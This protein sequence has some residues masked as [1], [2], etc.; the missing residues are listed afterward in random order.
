MSSHPD[1]IRSSGEA[2]AS[3]RG[4]VAGSRATG[5]NKTKTVVFSDLNKRTMLIGFKGNR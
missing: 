3:W 4:E 1:V 2:I 5:V